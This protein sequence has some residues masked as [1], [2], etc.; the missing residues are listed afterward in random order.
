MDDENIRRYDRANRVLTFCRDRAADIAPGSKITTLIA[1]LTP[2][3]E[4][5]AA[6]RIGQLRAPVSKS[7]LIEALSIDFIIERLD[8]AFMNK[9]RNDPTT[10]AAW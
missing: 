2:L 7:A 5:L 3:V 9:Y 10:I 1:A 4:Q 8:A 6:A